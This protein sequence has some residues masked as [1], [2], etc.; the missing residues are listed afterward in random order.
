MMHDVTLGDRLR[1]ANW[2]LLGLGVLLS[3]IG[4]VSVGAASEGQR[5]D[6]GAAQLRWVVLGVATCLLMLA[7]P[8]R[9]IVDWRYV[10]YAL[11]LLG[12]L[13]VLVVGSGKSAARWI[14]LGSFRMQPSE[15]MKVIIVITLAGYIRYGRSHRSFR[16]LVRPFVLTLVP[17][18][19]IM[20]QPDLGT[21]LLLMPLLFVML[22]VAGAQRAHLGII[23]LCGVLA[24]VALYL[25]P[26]L[27]EY[28][29]DRVRT[30]LL[31]S[32]E[33]TALLRSQGHHLHQSKIVVGTAGFLG[34]GLGE[35]TREATQFLPERHSDFVYPVF[36]TAFG[37][38][39][40]LVL[41]GL[42]ALFVGLLLRTALTVREPSGRLLAVG[43]ATLFATQTL[44]NIAM[45]VG[46]LPIVGMP[47]PFLSYGGSSLLTSFA[48]LGLILNVGAD[49]PYEF[50]RGDF[51]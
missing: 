30:F 34:H 40:A 41:F 23:A 21:A 28:Q 37:S 9:R 17:V 38:A 13:A 8:Y 2:P 35:E 42:Y 33:N 12:L 31:Q 25:S 5:M 45:T 26:V 46:L 49:H 48:A 15:I 3:L 39:G 43:V 19:L 51:D 1:R 32:S 47:L 24:G 50:G 7:V 6:Y 16:G 18:L 36:V 29:K 22:Y 44:I 11:G 10:W 14:Q 27:S 20:K 4:L